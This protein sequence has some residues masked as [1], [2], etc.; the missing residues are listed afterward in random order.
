MMDYVRS[1]ECAHY[2][3]GV[4]V[5]VTFWHTSTNGSP[6]RY[7]SWNNAFSC[8]VTVKKPLLKHLTQQALRSKLLNYRVKHRRAL[9]TEICIYTYKIILP[10]RYCIENLKTAE[11]ISYFS[12][13][14]LGKEHRPVKNCERNKMGYS[15]MEV[16][17]GKYEG[18]LEN[19]FL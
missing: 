2:F 8:S 13:K 5:N 3:N 4:A 12:T 16:L 18:R 14:I 7:K 11:A 19:S 15:R 10:E 6:F 1:R 9:H 17:K